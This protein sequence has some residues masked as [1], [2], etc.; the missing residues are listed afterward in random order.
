MTCSRFFNKARFLLVAVLLSGGVVRGGDEYAEFKPLADIEDRPKTDGVYSPVSPF[1][2]T[3]GEVISVPVSDSATKT[4]LRVQGSGQMIE[5]FDQILRIHIDLGTWHLMG[6]GTRLYSLADGDTNVTNLGSLNIAKGIGNIGS[7]YYFVA[8]KASSEY[9]LWRTDGTPSGSWRVAPNATDWGTPVIVGNRILFTG[10]ASETGYELFVSDGT[11]AGTSVLVDIR[12]GSSSSYASVVARHDGKVLFGAEDAVRGKEYW[13]TDGTPQGTFCL[14]DLSP[15]ATYYNSN[16]LGMLDGEFIFAGWEGMLFASDGTIAGTRSLGLTEVNEFLSMNEDGSMLLKAGRELYRTDGTPEGTYLVKDIE[17]DPWELRTSDPAF[18]AKAGQWTILTATTVTDGKELWTTSG[19]PESTTRL[20]DLVPGSGSPQLLAPDNPPA[21]GDFVFL[22]TSPTGGT[23]VWRTDG[24]PAGTVFVAPFGSSLGLSSPIIPVAARWCGATLYILTRQNE[25]SGF[26]VT[27]WAYDAPAGSLAFLKDFFTVSEAGR[28]TPLYEVGGKLRFAIDDTHTGPEWWTSDGTV[29][30]TRQLGP[31]F[32]ATAHHPSNPSFLG[33]LGEHT[34]FRA[35]RKGRMGLWITDGRETQ[36]LAYIQAGGVTEWNGKGYFMGESSLESRIWVTDGTPGGTHPLISMQISANR[37][38]IPVPFAGGFFFN[39]YTAEGEQG[40]WFSDGTAA[41]TRRLSGAA[42]DGLPLSPKLWEAQI[43]NNK[44]IF[45]A[46]YVI[47]RPD[48]PTESGGYFFAWD[49]HDFSRVRRAYWGDRFMGTTDAGVF[50]EAETVLNGRELH[51]TDGT[52]AGTRLVKD[53]NTNPLGHSHGIIQHTSVSTVHNNRLYFRG[54][55]GNMTSIH[56]S[57]G[58][59]AGTFPIHPGGSNPEYLTP[60][61]DDIF[62][63]D[64]GDLRAV[65]AAGGAIRTVIRSSS[66]A[67]VF[68]GT[69]LTYSNGAPL[70]SDGTSAGTRALGGQSGSFFVGRNRV[71]GTGHLG[72][73][74]VLIGKPPVLSVDTATWRSGVLERQVTLSAG[75]F[76]GYFHY[77][78]FKGQSGDTSQPLAGDSPDIRV[79]ADAMPVSYWVRVSG[80]PLNDAAAVVDTPVQIVQGVTG[81]EYWARH[82]FPSAT[83]GGDSP[84][85]LAGDVDGDGMNGLLELVMG[86]DPRKSDVAAHPVHL[87]R[88]VDPQ[89]EGVEISFRRLAGPHAGYTCELEGSSDLKPGSWQPVVP[90]R[91]E[92]KAEGDDGKME[93][94]IFTLPAST[95]EP[96]G[97]FRLRVRPSAAP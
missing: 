47:Y 1:N 84:M 59:A 53:L 41:G 90:V 21:T 51:I 29:E 52:E 72:E 67:V 25:G 70:R 13:I 74:V 22:G 73:P 7:I 16:F 12:P 11:A 50:F 87:R 95:G 85:D 65:P 33:N 46:D 54:Y 79:V 14:G 40:F 10:I 6:D 30:T 20:V 39:G 88:L 34:L 38:I 36:L 37:G 92:V 9:E 61:G 75:V 66:R 18:F 82:Y 26:S 76:P 64:S 56:V 44:L 94:V 69:L 60:L 43:F 81:I 89:G 86:T 5:L 8:R 32:T 62:Y 48:A 78:W 55:N 19:T 91:T 28:Q 63:L 49:G 96:Q 71:Y 83:F 17:T 31:F 80:D 45:F 3:A 58:T 93:S 4:Y 97:F 68:D 42:I 23:G 35:S 27:L 57:D 2:T 77:Q 24:T 15:G